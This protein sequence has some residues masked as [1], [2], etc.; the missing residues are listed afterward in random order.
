MDHS[1]SPSLLLMQFLS[2]HSTVNADDGNGFV[3]RDAS[4]RLEADRNC[5]GTNQLECRIIAILR[6]VLTRQF[7]V[8]W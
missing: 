4:L 6:S 1:L 2:L 5:N 7:L 8:S 3:E